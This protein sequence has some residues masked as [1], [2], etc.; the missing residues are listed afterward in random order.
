MSDGQLSFEE[1]QDFELSLKQWA[2]TAPF[3]ITPLVENAGRIKRAL[4]PEYNPRTA[5][6]IK[7][8]C[9]FEEEILNAEG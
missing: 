5:E 8:H 7:E 2:K 6:H 4:M 3:F 1:G 9:A